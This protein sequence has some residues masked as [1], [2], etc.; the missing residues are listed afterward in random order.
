MSDNFKEI[1]LKA[2][3]ANLQSMQKTMLEKKNRAEKELDMLRKDCQMYPIQHVSAN[4]QQ[5]QWEGSQAEKLLQADI[6]KG[7]YPKDPAQFRQ[8]KEE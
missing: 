8:S 5:P 3:A 1:D 2:F 7:G 6:A 4:G